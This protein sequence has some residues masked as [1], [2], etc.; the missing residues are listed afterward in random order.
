MEK[1]EHELRAK[2]EVENKEDQRRTLARRG[3]KRGGE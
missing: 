1:R 2:M 3:G